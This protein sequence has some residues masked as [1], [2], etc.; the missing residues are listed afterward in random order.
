MA[1]KADNA[2]MQKALEGID[3]LF[4]SDQQWVRTV[5]H[6]GVN[7]ADRQS[8]LKQFFMQKALGVAL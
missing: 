2:V 7:L 8:V 6:V 4:R 5:R 1:R 3:H